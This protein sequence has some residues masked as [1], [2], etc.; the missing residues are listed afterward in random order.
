MEFKQTL[1]HART[2]THTV[3]LSAL[4]AAGQS[5]AEIPRLTAYQVTGAGDTVLKNNSH[6]LILRTQSK[7]L[8]VQE[9]D[10]Y[11]WRHPEDIKSINL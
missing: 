3:S 9:Y 7:S 11:E 2:H 1:T 6:K 10:D 8:H 5:A 4:R